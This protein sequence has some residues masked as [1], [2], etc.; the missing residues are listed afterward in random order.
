MENKPGRKKE[1]PIV[2]L[3]SWELLEEKQPFSRDREI[4]LG[5]LGGAITLISIMFS[6]YFFALFTVV[7][8]GFL[9]YRGRQKPRKLTFEITSVGVRLDEDFIPLETIDEYNIIDEPGERAR[10]IFSLER[11]VLLKEVIPIYDVDIDRIEDAFDELGI[12]KNEELDRSKLLQLIS[13]F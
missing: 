13:L 7:V 12:E 10:L 2:S 5:V 8:V 9:I 6:S 1:E 3:V 4:F 11:Y